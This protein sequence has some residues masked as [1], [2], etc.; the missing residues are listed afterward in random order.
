MSSKK[1]S[2]TSSK[3]SFKQEDIKGQLS[4]FYKIAKFEELEND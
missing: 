1:Q 3:Q 4:E 2:N